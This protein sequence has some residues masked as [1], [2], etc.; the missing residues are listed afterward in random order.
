MKKPAFHHAA[1]E[2]LT[3]IVAAMLFCTPVFA[4]GEDHA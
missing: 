2:D 3:S 4:Q 1:F